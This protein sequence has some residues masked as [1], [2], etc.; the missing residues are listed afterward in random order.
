[1]DG[2]CFTVCWMKGPGSKIAYKKRRP[3]LTD[4]IKCTIQR[5][6]RYSKDLQK[7]KK[8]TFCSKRKC[9]G[10]NVLRME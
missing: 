6:S 8:K 3:K 7:E 1:M 10:R 4:I 5:K 2:F 9:K